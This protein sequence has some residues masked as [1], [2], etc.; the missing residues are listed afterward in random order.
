MPNLL[1]AIKLSTIETGPSIHAGRM[2][3][4]Q[5]KITNINPRNSRGYRV[6]FQVSQEQVNEFILQIDALLLLAKELENT[7]RTAVAQS[8]ARL[9]K[10]DQ[11]KRIP[12]VRRLR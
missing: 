6:Q 12:K 8:A 3:E 4:Q 11:R 10:S 9:D 2:M 5:V 7:F 1:K